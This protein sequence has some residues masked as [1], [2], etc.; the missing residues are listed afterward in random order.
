MTTS[1]METLR[2]S[3]L[4][5][6][7]DLVEVKP[8]LRF[9][10]ATLKDLL[11]DAETILFFG[12][13]YELDAQQLG[14]LLHR[15]LNTDL[16]RVLFAE[17]AQH[18]TDL[19]SYL[20]GDYDEDGNWVLG[21]IDPVDAGQINFS[22]DVPKG[23][24][25]PEVWAQLEVEV[26]KSIKDV[27]AKL[28]DAVALLPGKQGS[29]VFKSMMRMNAK[30]PTIGDYRASITHARQKEN[31]LI[32]DVSGS[33][34]E[35]T[36][37]AIVDDVVA[38]S[39]QANA[40]MAIVSNTT[41]YWQPGSYGVSDILA[42]AQYGGTYYETL[43]PLFDRDWGVV[44]TVADY[45]SSPSAKDALRPCVGRIDQVLDVSLVN[46][47]TF[48]AECVGQLAAD[49]TPLLIASSPYVLT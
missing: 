22:P 4:R 27:A 18:S 37:K 35:A 33:M 8:G 31:L 19:Q 34:N 15:V 42:A 7:L 44:I 32:L 23:E 29:M 36:V 28:N 38:L 12:K 46:R 43:A 30:R 5:R 3:E 10:L 47:P 13:V 41:T 2:P 39:Y 40:H 16:T 17:S 20:V 1:T 14:A 24:I 45:D 6:C 26:A 25:L 11:P 49:V 48:L 21:I 9:S